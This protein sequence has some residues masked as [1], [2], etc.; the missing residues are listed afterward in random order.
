MAFLGLGSF[1]TGFVTGFAESANKALQDDIDR[2]NT[3]VERVADL[4]VKRAIDEQN[5]RKK[6]LSDIEDAIKEAEGLFGQD[7]PRATAYAASL[8]KQQGSTT[9]LRSF[10][11]EIKNSEAYKRGDNLANFMEIAEKETPTGTRTEFANAFLGKP[12]ITTDYRLPDDDVTAGAGNLISALGLKPDISGKVQK[13]VRDE[14]SAMGLS[15]PAYADIALPS[16]VFKKEKFL[17]ANKTPNE[18]LEYINQQLVRPEN[19]AERNIELE[20]MKA[21]ITNAIFE[22]GNINDQITVLQSRLDSATGEEA[23]ELIKEIADKNRIITLNQA[24]TSANPMDLIDAN[25]NISLAKGIETGDYTEYRRLKEEKEK[26]GTDPDFA[27][28]IVEA[29]NDLLL[30]VKNGKV[31]EGS[32]EYNKRLAAIRKDEQLL[33]A[34][35]PDEKV[36]SSLINSWMSQMQTAIDAQVALKLP[37]GTSVNYALAKKQVEETPDG[38]NMLKKNAPDLYNIYVNGRE[39]E[40]TVRDEAISK[41]LEGRD[42]SVETEAFRAATNLGY[43]GANV[44][45]NQNAISS[46]E[47]NN[48][49]SSEDTTLSSSAPLIEIYSNDL[50]GASLFASSL[51]ED[52]VLEEEDYKELS[53]AGYSDEFISEVKNLTSPEYAQMSKLVQEDLNLADEI[54][55]SER[56]QSAVEAFS[57]LSF[58]A[59]RNE[60]LNAIMS[61]MGVSKSR[62]MDLLPT[63]EE[64]YKK[65]EEELKVSK[66]ETVSRTPV[67]IGKDLRK[68]TTLEEYENLIKEYVKVTGRN[69]EDAR[70]SFRPPK[71]KANRGGLM[72]RN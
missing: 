28:E 65:Q 26:I 3:R 19:S 23:A 48:K 54:P 22:S 30:D 38:L 49:I 68:A 72:A 66:D 53:E 5:E 32:E 2:I 14:M 1:G 33:K 15:E 42:P 13:Q 64:K 40:S 20:G 43:K 27:Q 8:L 31:V 17:L 4:R 45:T 29:R 9:A 35:K 39:I 62:A 69:E 47:Q 51:K 16:A 58:L 71:V 34:V 52:A 55:E 61:S 63:I 11:S 46:V 44:I 25:L 57:E 36:N 59:G 21:S 50:T 18:K 37:P 6:D 70:Q 56:L 7:D 10:V 12:T 41:V 24:R 67:D 60:K